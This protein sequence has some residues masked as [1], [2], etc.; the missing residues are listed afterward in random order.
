MKLQSKWFLMILFVGVIH[1]TNANERFSV[2]ITA[3]IAKVTV[4][5]QGKDVVI[6]RNQNSRNTIH[7]DYALTSRECPPFCI[8][9]MKLAEGVETI[10]ELEVLEYLKKL[11][12]GDS[13]ILVI[14]SRTPSWVKKGTIPGSINIP[15]TELSLSAGGNSLTIVDILT[16]KFGV[17]NQD[18]LFDYSNAKTLVMFCNGMWC[19]QSPKNIMTLLKLGYPA[20]KIKWYRG[21]MQDWHIL[22]LTTI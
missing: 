9:P 13:S 8:R 12:A 10:A 17:K 14:D 21:G 5:H 2:Q 18:D 20:E 22:G 4:K 7:P 19:G 15:W 6:Q 16:E 1:S 11:S 3:D